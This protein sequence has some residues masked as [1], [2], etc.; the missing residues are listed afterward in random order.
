M[1]EPNQLRHSAVF[2][3]CSVITTIMFIFLLMSTNITLADDNSTIVVSAECC[4][5]FSIFSDSTEEN[6]SS[7]EVLKIQMQNCYDRF[8]I[9]EEFENFE[10]THKDEIYLLASIITSEAGCVDQEPWC[11]QAVEAGINPDIWQQYVGYCIMNRVYQ[12]SYPDTIRNVFYQRGQYAETSIESVESG[13]VTERCISNAKIVLENY[14]NNTIPVPRN[15]VYQAEFE[16]GSKV[17]LKVG[18]TCF[19]LDE[20]LPAE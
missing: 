6:L 16:Q 3:K 1:L 19:C 17:F 15:M 9:P 18:K 14:Y 8:N 11:S 2:L 5:P 4:E 13:Y 12:N 7:D 20:N 10:E